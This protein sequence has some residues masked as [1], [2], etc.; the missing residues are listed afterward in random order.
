[1]YDNL[2]SNLFNLNVSDLYNDKE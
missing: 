1:M 2:W